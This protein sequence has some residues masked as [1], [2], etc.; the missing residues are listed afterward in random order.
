MKKIK[1]QENITGPQAPAT[2]SVSVVELDATPKG[3]PGFPMEAQPTAASIIASIRSTMVCYTQGPKEG[4]IQSVDKRI[5]MPQASLE[6]KAALEQTLALS[7]ESARLEVLAELWNAISLKVNWPPYAPIAYAYALALEVRARADAKQEDLVQ[8]AALYAKVAGTFSSNEEVNTANAGL[9]R[10]ARG[11]VEGF[12][13]DVLHEPEKGGALPD[14]V[15]NAANP[16]SELAGLAYLVAYHL[17]CGKRQFVRAAESLGNMT[18]CKGCDQNF[19]ALNLSRRWGSVAR[20]GK[21]G[22]SAVGAYL[23]LRKEAGT[24]PASPSS[25]QLASL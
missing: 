5:S 15:A 11:K 24:H 12:L 22:R 3:T 13:A 1:N 21:I 10:L 7:S 20:L 16:E 23:Y 14:A 17:H 25:L 2:P 6:L 9:L 8:A 4:D 19:S 18:Y